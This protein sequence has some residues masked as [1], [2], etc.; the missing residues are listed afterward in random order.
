[1]HIYLVVIV[2]NMKIYEFSMLNKENDGKVLPTIE[3]LASKYQ[4]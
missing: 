2:E 4:S 3:D 1:M